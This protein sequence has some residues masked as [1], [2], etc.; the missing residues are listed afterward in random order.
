MQEIL[1]GQQRLH[2]MAFGFSQSEHTFGPGI[3]SPTDP[4]IPTSRLRGLG[5][6]AADSTSPTDPATSTDAA[7][8][9]SSDSSLDL[10]IGTFNPSFVTIASS[11]FAV[12]IGGALVGYLA[13]GG[14]GWRGPVIGATTNSALYLAGTAIGGRHRFSMGVL[15]AL[16]LS[17][18]ACV[19][20]VGWLYMKQRKQR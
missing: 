17:T 7:D 19:A 9:S 11:V 10:G 15:N 2:P 18:V 4:P 12:A 3:H 6:T 5:E 20:T 16:T 13:T 8:T 1:T 14:H